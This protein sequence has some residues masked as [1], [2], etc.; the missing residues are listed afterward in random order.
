MMGCNCRHKMLTSYQLAI[1]IWQWITSAECPLDNKSY[2]PDQI[3]QQ[4]SAMRLSSSILLCG[5][6]GRFPDNQKIRGA[7]ESRRKKVPGTLWATRGKRCQALCGRHGEKVPGTLWV[8]MRNACLTERHREEVP[9]TLWAT[10]L[11]AC[12]TESSSYVIFRFD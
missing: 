2:L 6:N 5:L 12:L 3:S 8:T 11:N 7:R 1:D 10:T 4:S 9:G